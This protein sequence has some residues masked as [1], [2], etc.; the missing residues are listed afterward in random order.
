[1]C[2][3]NYILFMKDLTMPGVT[4]NRFPIKNLR[5]IP[6]L[7]HVWSEVTWIKYCCYF[8]QHSFVSPPKGPLILTNLLTSI[9]SLAWI[10]GITLLPW[11]YCLACITLFWIHILQKI[12]SKLLCYI[13][14]C[15]LLKEKKFKWWRPI[16]EF[17]G[18]ILY[19]AGNENKSWFSGQHGIHYCIYPY[20]NLAQ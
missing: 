6:C 1:M 2:H 8:H 19:P 7:F 13:T 17:A 14:K 12:F 11:F 10:T 4:W 18:I 3:R 9:I 20:R 5:Q 16:L 15:D